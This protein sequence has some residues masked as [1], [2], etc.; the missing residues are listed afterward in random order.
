MVQN[1]VRVWKCKWVSFAW[2]WTCRL[3]HFHMNFCRLVLRH[4]P[5]MKWISSVTKHDGCLFCG[6]LEHNDVTKFDK[7]ECAGNF[8]I[9]AEHVWECTH[10]AQ[11]IQPKIPGWGSKISWC[12][13]GRDRFERSRSTP[14]ARRVSR[15]Y[16]ISVARLKLARWRFRRWY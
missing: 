11:S 3:T 9:Y 16:W 5:I 4:R 15:S 10:W 12:R 8:L 13:I 2:K 1:W 6:Q 14:L 7:L